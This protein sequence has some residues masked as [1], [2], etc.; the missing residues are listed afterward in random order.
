MFFRVTR[1]GRHQY[2][3]IARSYRNGGKTKQQTLLSLGRLQRPY[4][5]PFDAL[6]R[7]GVPEQAEQ[8]K[9]R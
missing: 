2:V 7:D 5:G 6:L 9:V 8:S 3:Q 4:S 1:A